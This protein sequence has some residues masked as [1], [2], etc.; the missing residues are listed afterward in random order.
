MKEGCVDKV[1][2]FLEEKM[3]SFLAFTDASSAC[4]NVSSFTEM[5]A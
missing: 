4:A 3:K 5:N 1:F 2:F